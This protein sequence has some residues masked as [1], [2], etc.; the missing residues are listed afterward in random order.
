LLTFALYG[1][2]L[3]TSR[4]GH[5]TPGHNTFYPLDRRVGGSQSRS[6]CGGGESNSGLPVRKL[7]T[8]LPELPRL[9]SVTGSINQRFE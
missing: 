4:S 1:G 8:V 5:F 9:M 6:D 2:E 7:V 3:S